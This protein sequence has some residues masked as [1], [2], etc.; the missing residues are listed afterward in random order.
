[1]SETKPRVLV[2]GGGAREHALC[3]AVERDGAEVL[4]APGNAGVEAVARRV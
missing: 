2:V 3:W 4:C 1:M